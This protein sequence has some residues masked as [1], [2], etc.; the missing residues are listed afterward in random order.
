[1][2]LHNTQLALQQAEAAILQ[3]L[4][5]RTEDFVDG[6]RATTLEALWKLFCHVQ[7]LLCASQW[8][9]CTTAYGKRLLWSLRQ[10][11]LLMFGLAACSTQHAMYEAN[12][13]VML[14]CCR[15]H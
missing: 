11:L 1:M 2:Q 14:Q 8:S 9:F 3:P 7:V 6:D 15:Q 13:S 5:I 10:L 4:G 12:T